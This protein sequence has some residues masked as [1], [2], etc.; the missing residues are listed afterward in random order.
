LALIILLLSGVNKFVYAQNQS[1]LIL[2]DFTNY[3]YNSLGGNINTFYDNGASILVDTVIGSDAFDNAGRSISINYDVSAENSSFCGI[4]SSFSNIDL[5]N[6]NY[7]SFWIRGG[8]GAEYLQVQLKNPTTTSS[9]AIW[10]YLSEGPDSTWQ[11]VIIPLDAF[12]NFQS[13]SN[14]TEIVFVFENFQSSNN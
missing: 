6:Y 13:I 4:S 5:S 9:I 7:L 11:K 10:D 1:V 2:D 12:F 3:P 8:I 14:I